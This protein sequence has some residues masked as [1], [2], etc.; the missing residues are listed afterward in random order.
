MRPGEGGAPLPYTYS[1]CPE[2]IAP[3]REDWE[4]NRPEGYIVTF[5]KFHRHGFGS[6]PSRFMRALVYYYGVELQHFSPNAISNVAI[7]A[8]VC[9]GYLGT[10]PH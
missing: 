10:M 4:P 8:M 7:F 6:P 5:I 9:E 2:W 1:T 3:H